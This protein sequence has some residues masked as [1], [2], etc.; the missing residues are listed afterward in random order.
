MVQIVYS[1]L[2]AQLEEA[3]AVMAAVLLRPVAARVVVLHANRV[4]EDYQLRRRAA[5]EITEAHQLGFPV[6]E[7]EEREA[8]VSIKRLR[9]LHQPVL[10]GVLEFRILYRF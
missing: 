9:P 4:P 1:D 2:L 7:A 10:R 5:K 3:M 6:P 8:S